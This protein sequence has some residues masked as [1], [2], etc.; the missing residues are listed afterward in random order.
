MRGAILAAA[1]VL[2]TGIPAGATESAETSV[3]SVF[4]LLDGKSWS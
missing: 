1:V 2:L 3:T 4:E